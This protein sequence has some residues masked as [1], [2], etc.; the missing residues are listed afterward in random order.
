MGSEERDPRNRA[1]AAGDVKVMPKD[2]DARRV[3]AQLCSAK[4]DALI[5]LY[6]YSI[7]AA[8]DTLRRLEALG[9]GLL[10]ADDEAA[11]A[12]LGS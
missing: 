10:D 11:L 9:C 7:A 4:E 12:A 8:R 6:G 3:L 5:P 1:S 2:I